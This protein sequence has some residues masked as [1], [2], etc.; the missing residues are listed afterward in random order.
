MAK[1]SGKQAKGQGR[2]SS[3]Q[4]HAEK[5]VSFGEGDGDSV[6]LGSAAWVDTTVQPTLS[7][8]STILLRDKII[9]VLLQAE[10]GLYAYQI[11]RR[12]NHELA[13]TERTLY[14]MNK[15]NWVFKSK[16]ENDRYFR[17]HL[18]KVFLPPPS[19]VKLKL[20]PT[21]ETRH[22]LI[23][24]KRMRER[25]CSDHWYLLDAVIKDYQRTLEDD[26][27]D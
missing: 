26:C 14:E 2:D 4:L 13:A 23:L 9:D 18:T 24:L 6:L 10:E 16:G 25:L 21:P 27:D 7:I 1:I 22:R 12:V 15:E 11:A 8:R 5:P 17:F 20:H 19:P 3:M